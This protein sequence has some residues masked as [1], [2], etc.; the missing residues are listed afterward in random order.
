MESPQSIV[1]NGSSSVGGDLVKSLL[2]SATL[3]PA[4]DD[5][6][7]LLSLGRTFSTAVGSNPIT[8][9]LNNPST[10][11]LAAPNNGSKSNSSFLAN[12]GSVVSNLTGNSLLF[13]SPPSLTAS[14][15]LP[16]GSNSPTISSTKGIDVLTGSS[17]KTALVS[18]TSSDPLTN[19]SST[20]SSKALTTKS[21]ATV[22][23][24]PSPSDTKTPGITAALV[25]DTR[26]N[27][28][29]FILTI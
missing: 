21:L 8:S 26:A 15:N 19:Y 3:S 13:N 28:R 5:N 12:L 18:P 11:N 6:S 25:R 14:S 4:L 2:D 7:S 1:T 16:Q 17:S 24:S 9:G 10:S 29:K 22:A 27:A 23:G 20:S